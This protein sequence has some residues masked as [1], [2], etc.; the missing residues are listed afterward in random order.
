MRQSSLSLTEKQRIAVA[1]AIFIVC[2]LLSS[3]RVL[4]E[5]PTPG[6]HIDD[7]AERSDRRFAA[8]KMALPKKGIVGYVGNSGSPDD[9]YLAQYALAPLVVDNS[10][11]HAWVV[12]NFTA[13]APMIRLDDL[14]R[15]KDFGNGVMLFARH[16]ATSSEVKPAHLDSAQ[17]VLI[18]ANKGAQ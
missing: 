6:R 1:I 16:P 11:D 17:P 4:T 15:V 18:H 7:I 12:G 10:T 8:L 9:Y 3:A 14:Q 2:C 13:P 5:T